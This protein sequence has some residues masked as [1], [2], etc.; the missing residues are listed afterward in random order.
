VRVAAICLAALIVGSCSARTG[1]TAERRA[2]I[3]SSEL[4]PVD[5]VPSPTPAPTPA[6]TTPGLGGADLAVEQLVLVDGDV[7]G[8]AI[9]YPGSINRTTYAPSGCTPLDVVR[10]IDGRI[11][12]GS[13]GSAPSGT[14]Y[15]FVIDMDTVEETTAVLDAADRASRECAA[16]R[17]VSLQPLDVPDGGWRAAGLRIGDGGNVVYV[18][19]WQRETQIVKLRVTGPNGELTFPVLA[20]ALARKLQTGF[21][22]A[23]DQTAATDPG[24]QPPETG[25]PTTVSSD[26]EVPTEPWMD[27]SLAPLILASEEVGGAWSRQVVTVGSAVVVP[28]AICGY[29]PPAALAGLSASFVLPSASA[30]FQQDVAEGDVVT[31][32]AWVDFFRAVSMCAEAGGVLYS[33][34]PI[35]ANAA[36]ADDVVGVLLEIEPDAGTSVLMSVVARYGGVVIMLTWQANRDDPEFALMPTAEQMIRLLQLAAPS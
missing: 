16:S 6:T 12:R 19:Y 1:V 13:L 18:G 21:A 10:S 25:P 20:A 3:D 11:N 9:A 27:H 35:A 26:P 14:F 32:Q 15:N 33:A 29:E 34:L 2:E 5:S 17:R 30:V 23:D 22:S 28:G 8:W 31:A 4:A 7:A 36:G 24:S